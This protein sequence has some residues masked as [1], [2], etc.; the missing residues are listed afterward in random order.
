MCLYPNIIQNRKYMENKKNGG[1][2]PHCNDER[3]KWVSVG[4]GKCMECRKQKANGWKI[5]LQEDLRVNKNAMFITMTY[6]DEEL[7]KLE[8]EVKEL[9]GYDVDN[10]V[11]RISVR[12]FTENWRKEYK[13]TIRH[14]LVTE[15]GGNNTERLHIHGIVWTDK[16]FEDIQRKWKYGNVI[17]GNGKGKHYVND[18]T[19]GYIVK[20]ISKVDEKHKE[21]MSKMFVS[22]GIGKEYVNREDSKRNK[23]KKGETKETYI[24]Q[25]GQELALPIYYRNKIYTDEEKEKLWIEKLDKEERWVDGVKVDVSK[26]YDEYYKL[27]VNKRV[28]NERLGYG[29]DEYNWEL[30][31]YEQK[32]R[33][34]KKQERLKKEWEKGQ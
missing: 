9:E 13:K 33:N 31:K 25:T 24:T 5:R 14:W 27:L 8:K 32:R 21:Y 26:S 1:E 6:S 15:I 23:Y 3:V 18:E 19:V 10:E 20:Y 28:K 34:L 22:K 4:C 11:A 30:K 17:L 7:V 12:R 16:K 29:N 2:I